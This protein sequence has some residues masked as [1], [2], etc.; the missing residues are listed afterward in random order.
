M[1]LLHKNFLQQSFKVMA[2]SQVKLWHS[3]YVLLGS[4]IRPLFAK[5]VTYAIT[6]QEFSA[7][8]Q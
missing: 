7:T 4:A 6:A 8:F 3:K 1:L 5:L 2:N